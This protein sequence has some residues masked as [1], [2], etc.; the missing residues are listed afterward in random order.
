MKLI[1]DEYLEKTAVVPNAIKAQRRKIWGKF[2]GEDLGAAEKS[3]FGGRLQDSSRLRVGGEPLRMGTYTKEGFLEVVKERPD[4]GIP[5]GE[6]Y[7]GVGMK[8]LP[9]LG[10]VDQWGL[11]NRTG[12]AMVHP[13]YT[14][15]GAYRSH[16]TQMRYFNDN[17]KKLERLFANKDRRD[18]VKSNILFRKRSADPSLAGYD[19]SWIKMKMPSPQTHKQRMERL[20]PYEDTEQF[21]NSMSRVNSFLYW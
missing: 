14:R 15:T 9:S 8:E 3:V 20:V 11:R 10:G 7:T 17:P 16:A 4:Y 2:L 5:L 1:L 6:G 12:I 18:V 13:H 19:Q 21:K